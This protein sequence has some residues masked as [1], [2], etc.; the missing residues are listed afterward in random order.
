LNGAATDEN[1]DALTYAWDL[2][3]GSAASGQNVVHSYVDNGAYPATLSVSD[4]E[5]VTVATTR[6]DVSNVSPSLE[7]LS[8][9]SIF[10]GD[11][12]TVS[13]MF[14]DA[15][16]NDA[17]WHWTISW[18]DGETLEGDGTSRLL[19]VELS[20][21]YMVDGLYTVK[22]TVK[23][24]DQ[25]LASAEAQ[26]EVKKDEIGIDIKPWDARN[27]IHLKGRW[28]KYIPVAILSN[29]RLDASTVDV[30]T[31]KLE[32][33]G[34]KRYVLDDDDNGDNCGGDDGD[35]CNS[36]STTPS[37]RYLASMYDV[38]GDGDQDLIVLFSRHD[39]LKA[40]DLTKATT[41]MTLTGVS[42]V[43]GSGVGLATTSS[44]GRKISGVNPV[45]IVR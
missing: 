17:P 3:D 1:G 2:G 15:G 42:R 14:N 13:V 33:V 26:I 45:Q 34:V 38:D 9:A 37:Y 30:S 11:N 8:P 19:P 36:G 29:E 31:V 27:R 12:H 10:V 16:A 22:V 44:E 35:G 40:G 39:L 21:V 20:H 5:M 32:S 23:D 43:P 18:G 7:P 28:D 41:S 24:K 6:V 4:G 25:D